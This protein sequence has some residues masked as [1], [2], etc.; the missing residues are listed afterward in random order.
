[1][2][3]FNYY[4]IKYG[5]IGYNLDKGI[6]EG[7]LLVKA[8]LKNVLIPIAYSENCQNQNFHGLFP[9]GYGKSEKKFIHFC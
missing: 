6:E 5:K 9:Q 1:M 8:Y 4:F 3:L 2:R 7:S